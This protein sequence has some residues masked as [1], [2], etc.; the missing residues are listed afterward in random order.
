M[1]WTDTKTRQT[2][3]KSKEWQYLRKWILSRG[4][5]CE[6]CIAKDRLTPATEVHHKIDLWIDPAKRL[7]PNN[8]QPLCQSCH[9]TISAGNAMN[10][11]K[12]MT[13]SNKKWDLEDQLQKLKK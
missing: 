10:N 1:D 8:L 6:L 4:P 2:F 7:D 3:Y 13:P 11:E 5:L 9:N 12:D